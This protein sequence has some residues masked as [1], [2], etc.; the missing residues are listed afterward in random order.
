MNIL[1][2]YSSFLVRQFSKIT[3]LPSEVSQLNGLQRLWLLITILA[4]PLILFLVYAEIYM[5]INQYL[6]DGV[7][8]EYGSYVTQFEAD[9]LLS[10]IFVLPT[11][12]SPAILYWF[13]DYLIQ[14]YKWLLGNTSVSFS[15]KRE[16]LINTLLIIAIIAILA[17]LIVLVF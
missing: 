3:S 7:T 16:Y 17:L 14:V 6:N 4:T 15:I 11:L 8:S 12:L 10:L 9:D 2:K 1:K 13:F 5:P